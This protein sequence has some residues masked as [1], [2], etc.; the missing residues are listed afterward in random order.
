LSLRHDAMRPSSR[1][2]PARSWRREILSCSM[3]ELVW[4]ANE[5]SSARA[6]PKKGMG[7][8]F[9]CERLRICMVF[10]RNKLETRGLS[11]CLQG[12]SA[13]MC[14]EERPR[15]E[16]GHLLRSLVCLIWSVCSDEKLSWVKD[17]L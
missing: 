2:N 11:F 12:W 16:R 9:M 4:D 3:Q 6:N 15:E 17:H 8:R 1:E 5:T 14:Y 13:E 7:I 10:T